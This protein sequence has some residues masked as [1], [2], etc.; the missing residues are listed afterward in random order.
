MSLALPAS[1][2]FL[3]WGSV[4]AVQ[5]QPADLRLPSS[6]VQMDLAQTGLGDC[7]D[8]P[9]R[10]QNLLQA[11]FQHQRVHRQL[12]IGQLDCRVLRKLNGLGPTYLR[13]V[14]S[15]PSCRGDSEGPL[16]TAQPTVVPLM[17][18]TIRCKKQKASPLHST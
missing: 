15:P 11:C 3:P 9:S 4:H 13:N 7:T 17:S 14:T 10:R 2:R 5:H 8:H 1:C 18:F 12:G 6:A 16:E